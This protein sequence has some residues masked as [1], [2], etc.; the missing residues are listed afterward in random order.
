MGQERPS[1]QDSNKASS[2]L[3]RMAG[4]SGASV[5]WPALVWQAHGAHRVPAPSSFQEMGVVMGRTTQVPA[6]SEATVFRVGAQSPLPC[7]HR[8]GEPQEPSQWSGRTWGHSLTGTSRHSLMSGAI[9]GSTGLEV[10]C[11]PSVLGPSLWLSIDIPDHLPAGV[12]DRVAPVWT[13]TSASGSPGPAEHVG[14]RET[15]PGG[16]SALPSGPVPGHGLRGREP[17]APL[18]PQMTSTTLISRPEK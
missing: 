9:P 18:K 13:D 17:G 8:P 11:Y 1:W 6:A 10:R 2:D 5:G 7:T 14:D 3:G 4:T 12:W 16:R 15:S